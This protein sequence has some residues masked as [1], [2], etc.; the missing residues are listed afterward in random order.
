[1]EELSG[2]IIAARKGNSDAFEEVLRRFQDMAVGYAYALLG[3]WQDAED[4]AQ[5]AFIAA[6]YGLI[7]LRDEAAFPGWFRRVVYTQAQRR[8]RVKEPALIS[9]EQVGEIA[10]LDNGLDRETGALAEDVEAALDALPE[11]QRA[12]VLLHYMND[13]RQ[14]EIAAFLE[15]PLGTVKSRLYHAR[16]LMKER[17]RHL[18]DLS[19]QRPSRDNQFTEQVMRFFDAAKSGDIQ[20]VEAHARRRQPLGERQRIRAHI[21]LGL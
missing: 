8:L 11:A 16:K 17:I 1:M 3:D 21:A 7:N 5:E 18:S 20:A 6:F 2:L 13:F 15:I 14:H 10:I 12:V 19:G 9:L 4:A